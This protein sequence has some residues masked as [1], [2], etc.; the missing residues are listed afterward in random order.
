MPAST[1]SSSPVNPHRHPEMDQAFAAL[2]KYDRGSSRADLVPIDDAVASRPDSCNRSELERRLL[3]MLQSPVSLSAKEYI[4]GKL[5]LIGTAASATSLLELLPDS[6]LAHAA[7]NALMAIP[8]PESAA[9][10]RQSL[11]ILTGMPLLGAIQAVGHRQDSKSVNRLA[12]FLEN[13][14]PALA[15]AAAHALGLIGVPSGARALIRFLPK[16]SPLLKNTMADSC[17]RCARILLEQGQTRTVKAL[18]RPF[19]SSPWPAH[20]REAAQQCLSASLRQSQ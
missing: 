5:A 17:L 16:A 18:C 3:A 14:D 6:R 11:A 19:T 8:G 1:P 4:C 7:L 15:E 20:V 13:P 9:A 10:L 12:G 2:K